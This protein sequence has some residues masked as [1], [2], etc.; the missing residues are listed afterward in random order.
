[1][2]RFI[3]LMTI[4][5]AI[6]ARPGITAKELAERCETTTRT[7]YRD[8]ELLDSI[9][10][11]VRGDYGKGYRFGGNFALYPLNFDKQ[12]E[13]VFSI[14][15]SVI[16]KSKL[17][18]GFDTAYEKVMAAHFRDARK[19]YETLENVANIIQM[20]MPA[21]REEDGG[22]FLLPIM[23]AAIEQ[24]TIRTVYHTQMRNEVTEREIDPYYLVPRDQLL[25]LIG[26]CHLKQDVRTFRI[27]RFRQVEKTDRK[28]DKSQFD[29]A[30]YMKHTW[31]IRRGDELIK[32]KIRFA[33]EV[34]RYIKEEEMFV[35]PKLTDLPDGSL[36]FEVTVNHEQEFM[37]WVAKYGPSA[38]ILEPAEARKRFRKR[39]SEWMALYE[40]DET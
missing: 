36:L 14:L 7:I 10:P 31:S 1:M 11:I 20:G 13:M 18:P 17:P 8:L 15:P 37:E 27:S 32:F 12:E 23:E 29:L 24:R 33:P 25:Y 40:L 22:N 38:E 4:V 5:T 35:R 6:Q 34:A 21:Y 9:V 2:E 3:R 30:Q 26:Y 39:L 28:F 19:R 16:D